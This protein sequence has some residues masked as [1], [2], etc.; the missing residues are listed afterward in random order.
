[1]APCGGGGNGCQAR[2]TRVSGGRGAPLE[3]PRSRPQ[4]H[5]PAAGVPRRVVA[6]CRARGPRRG[7]RRLSRRTPYL[8]SSSSGGSLPIAVPSAAAAAASEGSEHTASGPGG[9]TPAGSRA[10]ARPPLEGRAPAQIGATQQQQRRKVSGS[11]SS[12]RSST[13]PHPES[14]WIGFLLQILHSTPSCA[15]LLSFV[16]RSLL[17]HDLRNPIELQDKLQRSSCAEPA[18]CS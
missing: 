7:R 1:M 13:A 4:D 3:G 5:R 6:P 12:S 18:C 17:P 14:E 16:D 15:Q 8:V 10:I 2:G 11:A 9:G